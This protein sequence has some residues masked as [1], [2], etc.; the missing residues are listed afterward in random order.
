[1]EQNLQ[2]E[3]GKLNSREEQELY[4][5]LL[6]L[7]SPDPKSQSTIDKMPKEKRKRYN[8]ATVKE[9]E[10]MKNKKVM[11]YIRIT[12][13]PAGSKIYIC[14]VNWVT[15]FVL[16]T[17]SKTKCRIC[18]GGHHYCKTFADCFAPTVNFCSVL[19]MLCLAAMFG[20]F[21]G[22]L[23]YSQAYLNADID[24]ECF[25]RAPDFLKEYDTDGTELIWKLK[26]VIYGHP[27]GSRLWA[28]CLTKKLQELGF[29]QLTTDQCV[30]AKW[31]NWDLSDLQDD[32]HFVFILVHSDDLIIISNLQS[33][34][35][36]EKRTL[37]QAFEGVDQGNL[38]S[39]CGVEVEIKENGIKLSME[40]Y[41][42]KIM[43]RFGIAN[44]AK[45]DKPIKAKVNKTECPEKIDE[46]R[47][48]TYLQIIG[49]II[50][51]YTHCRL[52]LAFPVRVRVRVEC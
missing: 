34:M 12:D 18:F 6:D 30:Y 1:M 31:H 10:G 5:N 8:D 49:F 4:N 27:K 45:E 28:E 21:I 43:Q 16:G 7:S 22:S 44:E 15:K 37:L 48:K 3:A 14:V 50:F 29:N 26:K 52:D 23:D 9:F 47:K 20:W 41:W 25:L 24:E 51:G 36:K 13:L 2:H 19:T 39:F 38:S 11:E 17:Y 40:Y 46:T 33:M 35:L 42:Q 32:S